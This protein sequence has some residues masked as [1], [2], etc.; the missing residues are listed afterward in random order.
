MKLN[1]VAFFDVDET[2]IIEKSMFSVL[3]Q[4]ESLE[5][6]IKSKNIQQTVKGLRERKTSRED[7]NRYFYSCFKNIPQTFV[8]KVAQE[9]FENKIS[10]ENLFFQPV[11]SILIG[12]Q[13]IGVKI[14]LLSG[15]S[16]SFLQPIANHLKVDFILATQQEVDEKG[17]F[18][19]NIL[20]PVPMIGEG[21]VQAVTEFIE[22]YS[23]DPKKCFA[24]GDHDSDSGFLSIVGIPFIISGN[25]AMEVI[26]LENN[27]PIIQS[28]NYV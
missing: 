8:E 26:A 18:T 9:Y 1:S 15:S 24:F 13:A 27:W 14:A 3:K 17:N 10:S 25:K 22:K 4:L 2:L 6:A 7:I 11:L 21:K 19:G 5:P 23:L 16:E 20:N 12:L 28:G